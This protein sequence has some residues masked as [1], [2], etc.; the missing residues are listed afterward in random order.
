MDEHVVAFETARLVVRRLRRDDLDEFA[1][2][3]GDPEIIRYMDDGEPL[4]REQTAT[5]IDITLKN[6]E[7]RGWGTF[8]ITAK[9]SDRLVGFAGFARPP[10]R[11]GIVEIIYGFEPEAWGNGYATE[12]A[13]GLIDFGFGACGMERIEAT[14]DPENAASRRVL[15]KIGMRYDGRF[16]SGGELTDFFSIEK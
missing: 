7:I 8:G 11:P 14:V 5:W 12:V 16:A 4:S 2:L 10:E 9:T 6:Y 13:R 15:E 1:R 3:C